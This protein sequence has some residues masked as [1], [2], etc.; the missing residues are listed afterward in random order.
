MIKWFHLVGFPS[1]DCTGMKNKLHFVISGSLVTKADGKWSVAF[2]AQL[3]CMIITF[4]MN[5]TPVWFTLEQ[6]YFEIKLAV[7]FQISQYIIIRPITP[8]VL[9]LSL[10]LLKHG[11]WRVYNIRQ[12][13]NRL[14]VNSLQVW[15]R[16]SEMLLNLKQTNNCWAIHPR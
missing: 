8:H 14:D 12:V 7:H 9:N 3:F 13:Q 15:R 4:I 10:S 16:L 6:D 5:N 11:V 2:I 1:S